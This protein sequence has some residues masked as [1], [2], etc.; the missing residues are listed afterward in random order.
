[1]AREARAGRDAGAAGGAGAGT[2]GANKFGR[3]SEL[4][5]RAEARAGRT[6]L[7][8]NFSTMPF[9]VM[10]ALP[11]DDAELVGPAPRAARREGTLAC[12]AEAMVMSASAGVMAGDDQLVRAAVAGGAALR[13]TTQSFEKIHRMDEGAS[14]RRETRLSV[15]AHG[16]LDYRPQPQIPFAGSDYAS[17]TVAELEDETA[18]LVYEEVLSCGRA[19]RGER[20]GYRRYANHVLVL[21]AGEP[22]YL[23]NTVYDPS[24]LDMEGLGMYEG[25]SHLANLVVVNAGVGE[26]AFLAAR[27]YLRDQT[28]VIGAAAGAPVGAAEGSEAVAGGITRLGSGDVAVRLLGH[29]AQRLGEVL[30]RVRALLR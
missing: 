29:R 6:V 5:L 16:Y 9:R 24:L 12:G 4:C 3:T 23:D 1:M 19:A 11:L 10:R 20:F 22:V 30:A 18:T 26:D 25:F 27:D 17:R 2:P 15:A 7:A 21:V 14:A 13:V 8:E 28:G